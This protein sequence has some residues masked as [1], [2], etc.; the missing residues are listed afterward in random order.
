MP[1]H[2]RSFD[3]GKVELGVLGCPELAIR[4]GSDVI[5]AA[6]RGKGTWTQPLDGIDEWQQ[7]HVSTRND[8]TTARILRSVE[9]AHTNVDE[10]GQLAAKLGIT[11]PPDRHG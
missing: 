1:S 7:L 8:G 5:V 10:I 2:W 6:V 9:K 4:S 11:A 3:N